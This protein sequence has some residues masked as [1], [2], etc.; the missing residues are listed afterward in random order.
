MAFHKKLM[1]FLLSGCLLFVGCRQGRTGTSN[2]TSEDL[3]VE[4]SITSDAPFIADQ[5]IAT[6]AV[7]RAIP[8]AYLEKARDSLHI[9]YQHTS[10]GTHVTRG[11]F[12]LPD[13]KEGDD[14]LFGITVNTP[15]AGKLDFNDYAMVD[16]AAP[17]VDAADLSRDETAFIQATRNFL[18]DKANDHIN[19]IMWSWCNIGGHL[20]A[21][22]YL[23]GIDSLVSEYG[24]GG[25]RIGTGEGQRK[26]PVTFI[27][28]TGHANLENNVGEGNPRDQAEIILEYARKKGLFCLDYY[29]IDTHDMEGNYWEDAGD[30]GNSAA[31]GGNFYR[32]WQDKHEL[33]AGWYENRKAPGGEV[34]FGAHNS[35]HITANRKAFAMWWILARI[36]GWDG[37]SE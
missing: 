24:P 16:Y 23:P 34:A 18:D 9:A 15:E 30:D 2:E 31:Y 3:E 25:S 33:G 32:D 20:P 4:A 14:L 6:E 36:A 8:P 22:N 7:L 17:G 27:L 5:H 19:V 26:H 35:Q 28:M 12:G 21:T 1:L 13:Y 11:M 10:H 29:G 37:V